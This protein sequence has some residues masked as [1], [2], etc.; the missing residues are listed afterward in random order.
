MLFS[1]DLFIRQEPSTME[2]MDLHHFQVYDITNMLQNHICQ[3]KMYFIWKELIGQICLRCQCQKSTS[4]AFGF[5]I[6]L[7]IIESKYNW[8]LYPTLGLFFSEVNGLLLWSTKE[9]ER[10][11]FASDKKATTPLISP[12]SIYLC[13]WNT[14]IRIYSLT[15]SPTWQ[16]TYSGHHVYISVKLFGLSKLKL[17]NISYPVFLNA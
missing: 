17:I 4:L 8:L 6:A 11:T 9:T 15:W 16:W 1:A 5:S 13:V 7:E 10:P 12:C 14:V 3:L 2:V